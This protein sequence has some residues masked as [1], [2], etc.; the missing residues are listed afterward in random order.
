MARL[1]ITEY[2]DLATDHSKNVATCPQE[3]AA[4]DYPLDIGVAS[5]KSRPF[6]VRTNI[7]MLRADEPCHLAFGADPKATTDMQRLEAGEITFRGVDPGD[8]L[9][10]I[11]AEGE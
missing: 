8:C 2:E 9:A 10:A 3:P 1:Q 6:G 5:T 11:L 4:A 7:V